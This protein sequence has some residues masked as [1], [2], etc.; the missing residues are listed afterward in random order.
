MPGH[1]QYRKVPRAIVT[2]SF[3]LLCV[4]VREAL[5]YLHFCVISYRNNGAWLILE[6]HF[7]QQRF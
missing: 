1:I 4:S 6:I 2:V 5:E 7:F 3:V